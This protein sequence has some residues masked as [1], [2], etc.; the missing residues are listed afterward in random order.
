MLRQPGCMGWQSGRCPGG[1]SA[2]KQWFQRQVPQA[3][4]GIAQMRASPASKELHRHA[5]S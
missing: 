5:E 2:G 4:D 1:A 3:M